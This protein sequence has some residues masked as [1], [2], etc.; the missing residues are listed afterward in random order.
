MKRFYKKDD[1]RMVMKNN[2][3]YITDVD[4]SDYARFRRMGEEK[5]L[6]VIDVKELLKVRLPGHPRH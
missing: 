2:K 4:S 3:L 6:G 1:I 5:L